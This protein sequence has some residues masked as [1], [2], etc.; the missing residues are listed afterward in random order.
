M[1]LGACRWVLGTA[2]GAAPWAAPV[3]IQQLVW[4]SLAVWRGTAGEHGAQWQPGLKVGV[5]PDGA[6]GGLGEGSHGRPSGRSE[7]G[8]KGSLED[9]GAPSEKSGF[10]PCRTAQGPVGGACRAPGWPWAP[11]ELRGSCASWDSWWCWCCALL[12][13]TDRVSSPCLHI[14]PTPSC[15][16]PHSMAPAPCGPGMDAQ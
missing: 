15:T 8:R 13:L 12:P 10:L 3:C 5:G 6:G 7:G 16:S 14:L 9:A 4:P 11:R 2:E 1:P